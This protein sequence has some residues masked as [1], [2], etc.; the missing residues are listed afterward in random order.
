MDLTVSEI[1]YTI[2]GETTRTGFPAVFVRLAGCNLRCRYCDT[3]HAWEGGSAMGIDEIVDRVR[4]YRPVNHVT[5]TGGEPLLQAA[6]VDLV[7]RLLAE[8]FDVQI[9]TNGSVFL[10]DVPAAARKIVDVKTPSSGAAGSFLMKNFKYL[11]A[12]DELKFVVSSFE[13]YAFAR[14]F[15]RGSAIHAGVVV[16]FSANADEISFTKLAEMILDDRLP[17]RLNVQLHKILWPHG[18]PSDR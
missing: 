13:D 11:H 6:C 12:G 7:G 4:G 5:V 1:F 8:G 2:E 9:E 17:V 15:I 3:R 18:E 10:A 14:D 16:N